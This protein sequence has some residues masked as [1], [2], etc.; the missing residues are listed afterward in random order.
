MKRYNG[1]S[2]I[3]NRVYK[4]YRE[5]THVNLSGYLL[6]IIL[7]LQTKQSMVTYNCSMTLEWDACVRQLCLVV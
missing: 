3:K 1:S 7:L 4:N 6:I 5:K 2:D